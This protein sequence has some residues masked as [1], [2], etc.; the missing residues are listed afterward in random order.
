MSGKGESPEGV[1]APAHEALAQL[2]EAFRLPA[3]GL[4]DIAARLMPRPVALATANFFGL[5]LTLSPSGWR[6]HT[7]MRRAFGDAA[8]WN[9]TREYLTCPLRDHAVMARIAVGRENPELREIE[10]RN[11][12]ALVQQQEQSFILAIGHYAREAVITVYLPQIIRR[13]LMAIMAPIDR[14][15]RPKALRL[16]LQLTRMRQAVARVQKGEDAIVDAGAAG[17]AGQVLRHLRKPGTVVIISADVP[18]THA[19]RADRFERPFAGRANQSFAI[20]AARLSRLSQRP[21]VTCVPFLD[22]DGHIE[23]DWGEPIAPPAK[24]DHDADKRVTSLILDRLEP[25]V[26]ERPAQYVLPIGHERRWDSAQRRWLSPEELK[27]V[28]DALVQLAG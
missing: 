8:S 2:A 20:G 17:G 18:W 1:T 11:G 26:G 19:P 23:L 21:I 22:A 24:E 4:V 15:L 14:S 3:F 25:A 6:T 5:L 16:R 28:P 13:R 12:S 7:R 10:S 27:P 9:T